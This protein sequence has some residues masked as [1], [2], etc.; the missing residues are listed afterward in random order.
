MTFGTDG[1]SINQMQ[2]GVASTSEGF[3]FDG[4]LGIGPRGLT[5]SALK[6]SRVILPT[7]TDCL[8]QQGTIRWP[9][10]GIFFQPIGIGT[11][12]YGHGEISFGEANPRRHT[13]SIEYTHPRSSWYWGINQR[14]TY[15]DTDIDILDYTAVVAP[16]FTLPLRS[17]DAFE[18]YKAA[19]GGTMNAANGLLQISSGQYTALR[20]LYF[21]IGEN[22]YRLIPNAQIW[23]RFLNCRLVGGG[24]KNDIFLIVKGLAS[25]T[26][27]GLD[28]INGYV[29]LQRFYTVFDSGSRPRVGFA[30]TQF[31]YSTSN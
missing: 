10:V 30:Q 21:H 17:I 28:F 27:S 8:F 31:T 1:L 26:G 12:Q 20:N 23:P 5:R 24:G 19:T 22:T 4:I 2:F 3:A 11:V 18:K 13:G 6:N 9:V 25:P 16:F 7:V 29:F 14:I 15:G